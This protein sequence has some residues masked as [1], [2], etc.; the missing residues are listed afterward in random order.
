MHASVGADCVETNVFGANR[1]KLAIHG[2]ADRVREINRAGVKLARDVRESTGRACSVLGSIVLPLQ[3][4]RHAEYLNPSFGRF[5]VV[6]EVLD[7]ID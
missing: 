4:F 3:S 2:L 7:A 1:F 5:E 6:A